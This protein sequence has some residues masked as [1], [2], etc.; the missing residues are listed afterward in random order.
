MLLCIGVSSVDGTWHSRCQPVR[1]AIAQGSND[2]ARRSTRRL[3]YGGRPRAVEMQRRTS[4]R[5]HLVLG[6]LTQNCRS[7]SRQSLCSGWRGSRVVLYRV[8][9]NGVAPVRRSQPARQLAAGTPHLKE[10]LQPSAAMSRGS[11]RIRND[12]IDH[13]ADRSSLWRAMMFAGVRSHAR[14]RCRA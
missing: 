1:H 9:D 3:L 6:V 14:Y 7:V 10:R 5:R 4:M 13:R 11:A 8:T 12:L 2:Q